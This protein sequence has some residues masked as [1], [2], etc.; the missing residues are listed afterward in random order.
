MGL[1]RAEDELYVIG[2]DKDKGDQRAEDRNKK[3][4]PVDLIIEGEFGEKIHRVESK[5]N[6]HETKKGLTLILSNKLNI[7]NKGTSKLNFYEK[8][9]GD[10]IHSILAEIYNVDD[11]VKIEEIAKRL[12]IEYPEFDPIMISKDVGSFINNEAIKPFFEVKR[13]NVFLEKNF[14]DLDGVIRIDRL[15]LNEEEVLI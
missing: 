9:R 4:F 2:V 10:Y 14:A 1:T 7:Q 12:N 6:I 13:E 15:I 11:I 8:R 5:K 3:K